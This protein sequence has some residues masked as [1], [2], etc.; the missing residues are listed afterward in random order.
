EI[1]AFSVRYKSIQFRGLRLGPGEDLYATVGRLFGLGP[2][3]RRLRL[4]CAGAVVPSGTM[5]SE[6]PGR[7][8]L[9]MV[10]FPKEDVDRGLFERMGQWFSSWWDD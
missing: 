5:L 4:I 10:V 3:Q 2:S 6:L 1:Q 8:P 7:P 9:L